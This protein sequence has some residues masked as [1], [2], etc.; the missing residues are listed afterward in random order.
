MQW[1]DKK[2]FFQICA[3]P[4]F[5]LDLAVYFFQAT[6]LP[7]LFPKELYSV[8]VGEATS[9]HGKPRRSAKNPDAFITTY[10]GHSHTIYDMTR[11]A[12]TS[13]GE[14][15]ATI[16]RKFVEMKKLKATDRFPSKV[17]DDTELKKITY[18]EFGEQIAYF[19]AGLRSVGLE[20]IP[21]LDGSMEAFDKAKGPFIIVFFED[22]CSQWTVG[23]QGAFTQSITVATCYATLGEDAVISAVNETGATVLFLNWK[24][25]LKFANLA[26]KM[27]SLKT[28]IAST[29]EMPDGE[30]TP[31]APSGSKVK[32]LSSDELLELGKENAQKFPPVPPKVSIITRC[33]H[34]FG[35]TDLPNTLFCVLS[36]Y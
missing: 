4:I 11:V 34:S 31:V 22:T 15:T 14:R 24:N 8:A 28:I 21:A 2:I 32:I 25:S 7:K 17:F 36:V 19:G 23:L 6:W 1:F 29:H 12:V 10:G 26:T 9:H 30:K 35:I 5:V 16:S 27:P 3:L 20:P 18:N 13:F 33:S